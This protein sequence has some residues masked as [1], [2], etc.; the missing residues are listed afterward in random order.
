MEQFINFIAGHEGIVAMAIALPVALIWDE[1]NQRKQN[2]KR[3]GGNLN[4]NNN[5]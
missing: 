1:L 5:R 3:K 2:K 4:E